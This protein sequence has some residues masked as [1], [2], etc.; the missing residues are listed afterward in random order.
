[1]AEQP[2]SVYVAG[3][4]SGYRVQTDV[5]RAFE[6][7]QGVRVGVGGR[8]N[9]KGFSDLAA[10]KMNVLIYSPQAGIAEEQAVAKAFPKD[11]PQPT[12]YVFGQ[13]V[14]RVIVSKENPAAGLTMAQLKDIYTGKIV[15]WKDVGSAAGRIALYGGAENSK[16]REMFSNKVLGGLSFSAG[17]TRCRESKE[18]VDKVSKDRGAV[19]VILDDRGKLDTVKSLA[20]GAEGAQAAPTEGNIYDKKYPLTEELILY[21]PPG[22]SDAARNYCKFAVGP[23]GA[24]IARKWNLYAEYDRQQFFANRRLEELKA[25]KGQR[26][27]VIG[28]EADKTLMPD[29]GAEYVRAKAVIQTG[30]QEMIETAARPALAEVLWVEPHHLVEQF[31]GLI[32]V[33]VLRDYAALGLMAL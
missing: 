16:G 29:V 28:V 11:A 22:A 18:V 21:L 32:A 25:G 30:Y 17:L 8:D 2:Q 20:L 7:A 24:G 33:V 14:V 26:I 13:F 19:G 23:D 12:R 10:G 15:D 1:M 5:G 6:T 4:W 27:T 31:A 3:S 9:S